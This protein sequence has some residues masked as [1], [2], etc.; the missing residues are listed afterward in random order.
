M[1]PSDMIDDAARL[2]P[3]RQLGRGRA[4]R[5]THSAASSGADTGHES[6]RS[7]HGGSTTRDR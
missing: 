4:Q 5:C 6:G 1:L 7:A 3:T 2:G